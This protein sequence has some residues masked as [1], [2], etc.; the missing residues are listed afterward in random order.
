MESFNNLTRDK[1]GRFISLKKT[2]TD[3]T[4]INTTNP[5][6]LVNIKI[7]NPLVYIKH[8]WKKIMANEGIEI[9]F[10]AKPVTVFWVAL[11]WSSVAFGLGGV[12]LPTFFPWVKVDNL[13]LSSPTPTATPQIIKDTAL[14]GTLTKSNTVPAIFYL[15]T[16]STE[17]ITLNVPDAF[18]LNLLIGKRILAVGSYDSKSKIL[19]VKDIQN[20]EI[21]SKTPVP[22][23][24]VTPSPKPTEVPTITPS[25]TPSTEATSFPAE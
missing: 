17:A 19:I 24:T 9:K 7:T 2:P 25:V 13:V 22:I 14:R 20:L 5:P 6:V 21:L 12:V 11:I 4:T 10:K 8:W 15:V 16:T 1:N 3:S 23:P 18:N